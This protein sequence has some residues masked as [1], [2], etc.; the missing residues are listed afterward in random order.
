MNR[1]IVASERQ[2]AVQLARCRRR[3]A[4]VVRSSARA[5]PPGARCASRSTPRD[6]QVAVHDGR[7]D[8]SLVPTATLCGAHDMPCVREGFAPLGCHVIVNRS[9]EVI[10]LATARLPRQARRTPARPPS[11][12]WPTS[13]STRPTAWPGRS[14][15]TPARPR[16]RRMTRSSRPGGSGRPCATRP[17]SSPGSIGSWSTPAGTGCD[18]D[19]GWRRTSRPRSPS[20]RAI[21]PAT[22][23]TA[24]SSGPPSRRCRPITSSSSR[25]ATTGTSPSTTS[26]PRLDIPRGTVQS[27]LHYALKRLHDAID[28]A[29]TKGTVR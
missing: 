20:P 18:P 13:I 27:R 23:R 5:S 10:E 22:P 3:T 24:T 17:G 12:G 21:T 7:S 14:C 1:L 28:T 29:E 9:S 2:S 16:T 19:A 6:V 26:R 15:A 25:C 4:P 11:S 8:S